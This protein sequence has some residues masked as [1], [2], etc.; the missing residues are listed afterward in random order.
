MRLTRHFIEFIV[1]ETKQLVGSNV[2]MMLTRQTCGQ[3]SG[4]SAGGKHRALEKYFS[5]RICY[6][7]SIER[8][9]VLG[10]CILWV[11]ANRG[12]LRSGDFRQKHFSL[13]G[14]NGIWHYA[15]VLFLQVPKKVHRPES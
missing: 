2:H 8:D 13:T 11:L 10:L 6:T 9:W 3:R 15:A 4:M 12:P 14:K 1:V 7:F 5:E